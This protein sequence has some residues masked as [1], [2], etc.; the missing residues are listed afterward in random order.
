MRA[1]LIVPW[2]TFSYTNDGATHESAHVLDKKTKKYRENEKSP[3][4]EKR[5][6]EGHEI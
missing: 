5:E 6:R 2:S 1:H 3:D 4:K